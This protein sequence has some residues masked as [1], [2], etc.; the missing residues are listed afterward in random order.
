[1][2]CGLSNTETHIDHIFPRSIFPHLE[3]DI[4]NLQIL[5]KDCNME[6]SNKDNTDYRTDEQRKLC[7]LK[8][9]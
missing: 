5:C 1:M 2:K 4:H 7:S 8:N 3:Y 6:K 9:P